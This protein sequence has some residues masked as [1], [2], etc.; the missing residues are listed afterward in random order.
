MKRQN[1]GDQLGE[2]DGDGIAEWYPNC[3]VRFDGSH[4]IATPHTTNPARRRKRKEEIITVSEQ[5]GKLKLET[6]PVLELGDD[7]ENEPVSP[8]QITLE[9]VAEEHAKSPSER[10]DELK[11]NMRRLTRKQVFDE[12]YNKYLH[13]KPKERKTAITE[14]MRSLFKTEEA[15]LSFVEEH[16]HRRWRNVVERRKR[17]ARKAYNQDFQWFVTF[18]YADGKHTEE[19]FKKRLLETL[20]RLTTRHNWKYMGVWERDKDRL[21]FHALVYIPDG[22][23]VGEFEEVTDYNKKTGRQ[24]TFTQNTFFADKFGRNEF[25]G[26]CGNTYSYGKSIAYIMKYMEKQNVKAVYSRGLYEYFHS[27]IQGKDVV[28]KME[29]IDETDNRLILSPKF[30]CWDEGVKI[31]VAS[32]ET[33]A[34]LPKSS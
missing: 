33:I 1:M 5:D 2:V 31:G 3:K 21:H 6:P 25:D 16:C 18:T 34:Q 15:F 9:Q 28:A 27:D 13:L 10:S 17:F 26:I 7:D 29:T 8:E 20:R 11:T 24:K 22:E 4:Y 14:D 30:T 19:S 12:L 23:T 32:P